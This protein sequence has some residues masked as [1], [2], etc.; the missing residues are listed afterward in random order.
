MNWLGSETHKYDAGDKHSNGLYE[1]QNFDDLFAL[2]LSLGKQKS[3]SAPEGA[4]V[5]NRLFRKGVS[6]INL[7]SP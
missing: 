1:D 6:F 4:D 5:P 2:F 3:E 7:F